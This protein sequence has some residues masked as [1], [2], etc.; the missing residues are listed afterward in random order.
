[1]RPPCRYH[2]A[3]RPDSFEFDQA[4]LKLFMLVVGFFLAFN[5]A[6]LSKRF[7]LLELVTL[8]IGPLFALLDLLPSHSKDALA[9]R[10]LTMY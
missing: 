2:R 1:M 3:L 4:T 9:L 10:F 7:P 8:K 6:F 5:Q